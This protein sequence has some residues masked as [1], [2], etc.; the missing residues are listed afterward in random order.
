MRIAFY[1]PLKS[2]NHPIV[3]GDR[4]IARLLV[5]ALGLIGDTVEVV[6]ELRSYLPAP[7]F[8]MLEDLQRAA[9]SERDRLTALWRSGSPPDIWF[10]YHP[11]YKS[12]D[13]I[14]PALA[15]AFSIPYVT[16]EAS[17][18]RRRAIA[19][20][21]ESQSYVGAAVRA[22]AVNFCLTRRDKE[23]LNNNIPEAS[24]AMLSPFI[25]VTPFAPAPDKGRHKLVTV[26]MMRPGDKLE[27][28]TRLAEALHL[29]QQRQW[30]LSIVGDGP[31]REAVHQL[32][33]GFE[34]DRI[35]W[36]GELSQP[37]VAALLST[38]DIYVWPGCGEAFGLAY[39]EALAS[40]LPVVAQD[41]SGVSEVVTNGK[42][43]LLT[44]DGDSAAYAAAIERLLDNRSERDLLGSQARLEA[45]ETH[46]LEAA[47]QRLSEV[48]GRVR[49]S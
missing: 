39:L 31:C 46:S 3:S 49:K 23:G 45:L 8:G 43:G 48:I 5:R 34:T 1:A 13:L 21:A 25:D 16:A 6:S 26:A 12:P 30:T 9:A 29:I 4:Q 36:H 40:G 44:Q 38:S 17:F 47:A 15:T 11:Y 24:L 19:A 18:S 37:E 28:Y 35:T 27:S 41:T 20:W 10:T 7:D 33:S 32:F 14:G 2:P 22:A 42:T